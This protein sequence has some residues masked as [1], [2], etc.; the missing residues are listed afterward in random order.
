[1]ASPLAELL[2]N[3]QPLEEDDPAYRELLGDVQGNLLTGHGKRESLLLFLRF[4]REGDTRAASPTAIAFLLGMLPRG[5][6]ERHMIVSFLR[7]ELELPR[8][9][10]RLSSRARDALGACAAAGLPSAPELDEFAAVR[11]GSERELRASRAPNARV[12]L[13][14]VV[15][16]SLSCSGYGALDV[17]PPS[18]AAFREGMLARRDKLAD[19]VSATRSIYAAADALLCIAYDAADNREQQEQRARALALT[20][21]FIERFADVISIE[22][23]RALSQPSVRREGDGSKGT[24]CQIEPFG[25]RDGISQPAF[26]RT[27]LERRRRWL[28]QSAGDRTFAP[29]GLALCPDPNGKTPLSCGS[30]LVFRKLRQDVVGFYAQAQR[31]FGGNAERL[32]GRDY[33]GQLLG[34]SGPG[35]G[36]LEFGMDPTGR[37]CPLFAHVRKVNPRADV[38]PLYDTG[39]HRV[40]RRSMPYG[41]RIARDARGA[42]LISDGEL[43]LLEQDRG[44]DLGLLFMCAQSDIEAQF[45]HIQAHWA[46]NPS[47]PAGKMPG[48]DALIGQGPSGTVRVASQNGGPPQYEHY[49]DVV[50]MQGGAYF[51]VPSV[52]FVRSLMD[53]LW[54]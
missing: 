1:M 20:R 16:L 2:D 54:Q 34:G 30:Y 44:S 42:P 47:F 21:A 11:I 32:V 22:H 23:G 18:S 33:D 40:V 41:P 12:P 15:N 43:T 51:F 14:F 50:E 31:L 49:E 7:R 17:A 9:A 6:A 46:N 13:E 5:N 19:P 48:R 52:S 45:E 25:F 35:A 29:L 37:L 3:R 36:E 27:Q 53:R 8:H 10:C 28:G 4:H 38:R 24:S 39:R 26:Y